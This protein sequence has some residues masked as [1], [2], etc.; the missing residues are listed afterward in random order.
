LGHAI[1]IVQTFKRFR[2]ALTLKFCP[3]YFLLRTT[4][5]TPKFIWGMNGS[6]VYNF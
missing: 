4:Q 1:A 5:K 6:F 2:A 3:C